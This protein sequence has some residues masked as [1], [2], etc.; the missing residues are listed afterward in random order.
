MI[1]KYSYNNFLE[2]IIVFLFCNFIFLDTINGYLLR[3]GYFSISLAFK[4]I[5]LG[6]VMLYLISKKNTFVKI[7]TIVFI[8]SVYF[9]IHS[10]YMS[11]IATSLKG[12]DNLIKFLSMVIFY[13]FFVEMII[14]GK[15]D[16]LIKIAK[17]SFIF[18]VINFLLGYLG[19]G[20]PM[21]GDGDWAVGTKGL[22]YAGNEIGAVIITSGA[23]LQMY[24]IEQKRYMVFLFVSILMLSMS[25]LL[26]SKV[27]ILSALLLTLFF[28]TI[29][30]MKKIKSLKIAKKDFYFLTAMSICFPLVAFVFIWYA[31]FVSNLMDRFSYFYNK[32][33]I[34]TFLLSH[35][36][37]WAKEA[38]EVFFNKYNLIEYIFGSNQWWMQFISENKAT[39]I[40]PIDFIMNYGLF[41]FFLCYGFSIFIIMQSFKNKNNPYGNYVAF[42]VLLLISISCT[43][44]H[45]YASGTAG[46]L[47]AM[48][49]S[50][51][52][53]RKSKK[54]RY[55][56]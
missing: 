16:M 22:I 17:Y 35:R 38:I 3:N 29:K 26:T 50:M 15:T 2:K 31:L 11:S 30:A 49:H 40:D 5:T 34:V 46:F 20:Y 8:L 4:S 27:S 1:Y 7:S 9:C 48:L 44:G 42:M 10:L 56:E 43:G 33:D 32:V 14:T 55:K 13:L 23:I 45:I 41:G 54:N 24:F 6:L 52:N 12:L 36:N 47:I 53:Y 37:I 51:V 39:E 25:A 21:Y 18:L 28:S 19:L